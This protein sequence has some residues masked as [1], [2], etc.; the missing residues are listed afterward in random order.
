MSRKSYEDRSM[1][2]LGTHAAAYR[3]RGLPAPACD[4]PLFLTGAR[5][6]RPEWGVD[7]PLC[8]QCARCHHIVG[9]VKTGVVFDL[10]IPANQFAETVPCPS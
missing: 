1:T 8:L 7:R 5:L 3:K 6:V 10:P 2:P 4:G 9:V